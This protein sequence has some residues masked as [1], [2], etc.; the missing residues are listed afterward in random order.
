MAI[1]DHPAAIAGTFLDA[2]DAAEL[3]RLAPRRRAMR[4]IVEGN[5]ITVTRVDS[6]IAMTAAERQALLNFFER[7][8]LKD[9]TQ[10]AALGADPRFGLEP[11]CWSFTI[12]DLY[13]FLRDRGVACAQ[14]EYKR[15]RQLL[16]T[17]P[18]NQLM[19]PMGA[20]IK[21]RENLNNVDRSRYALVWST[22]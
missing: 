17:C 21:I 7:V 19:K 4:Y 11:N 18:V 12:P 22:E 2:A 20:E 1:R 13:F 8:A 5:P 10:L 15:F 3:R 9:E 16:F 14:L 6:V